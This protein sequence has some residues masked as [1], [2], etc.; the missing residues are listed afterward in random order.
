MSQIH[1]SPSTPSAILPSVSLHQGRP[2]TTSLDVANFFGKRHDNVMRSVKDLMDNCPN[3]F[4]A[5]NFEVSE[6]PDET[7]RSL[8]MFTLYRDGF[9]LL[10]MGYTGKRALAVKL[11]YI[12]AFNRI[13]AALA[14]A[15]ATSPARRNIADDIVPA[16]RGA[17]AL[18]RA[19][20]GALYAAFVRWHG[21]GADGIP[22]KKTFGVC[23]GRLCRRVRSNGS[24]YEGIALLK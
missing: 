13:E 6:Y 1:S 11:A 10:V 4:T 22:S 20:A 5:L 7:G 24:W 8:P 9:M 12:E 16:P 17:D 2:A 19:A 18:A 21:E 23:L 3:D 15:P 14:A